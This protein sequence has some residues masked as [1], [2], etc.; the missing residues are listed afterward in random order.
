VDEPMTATAVRPSADDNYGQSDDNVALVEH[1]HK[2]VRRTKAYDPKYRDRSQKG[3][4]YY[5]DKQWEEKDKRIVKG[6]DQEAIVNNLVKPNIRLMIGLMLAQPFDWQAKPVGKNDDDLAEAVTAGLKYLANVNRVADLL[7]WVYWWGLTYGVSWTRIGPYVRW[8]DARREVCQLR[9]IDPREVGI[10]PDSREPDASDMRFLRWSRK[11]DVADAKRKWPKLGDET[12]GDSAEEN[13]TGALVEIN[14]APIDM[15]PPPSM[16][17]D[18]AEWNKYDDEDVDADAKKVTVHEVWEIKH[19]KVWLADV[20][21][22]APVEFDPAKDHDVLL[23]ARRYWQDTLPKVWM[24]VVCGPLLLESKRSIHKH[25]RIPFVPYFYERDDFGCPVSAVESIKDMQREE[26]YRRA[27]M[28]YELG[29][30]PIIVDPEVATNMGMSVKQLERHAAKRSPIWLARPDQVTYPA[31]GNMASQ[32]FDLMQHSEVAIQKAMGSNDHIMG[33][34]GPAESGKS[35]E[36]SV[37]QGATIQRA[38]VASLH[39]YH[40]S[41]GEMLCSDMCQFHD[42][43]WV[44]RV[45]DEGGRD[46]SFTLNGTGVDP[47]TGMPVKVNDINQFQYD[48]EL[49]TVPYS[50]THRQR[51]AERMVALYTAEEDPTVRAA[52]RRIAIT[53]DDLPGK[54]GILDLLDKAEQ[55][56]ANAKPEARKSFVEQIRIDGSQITPWELGQLLEAEGIKPDPSRQPGQPTPAAVEAQAGAMGGAPVEAGPPPLDPAAALKAQVDLAKHGATL[57]HQA[58]QADHDRTHQVGMALMAAQHAREQGAQQHGNA[59][60]QAE[61]AADLAPPP[62]SGGGSA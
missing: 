12:P 35:K 41:T 1:C 4:D 51:A 6:R 46:K 61:Q 15:T 3:V 30:Q 18:F 20:G 44:V 11:V 24:H 54:R 25:D 58:E 34:D 23:K 29:N 16:W 38:A 47:Q 21:A 17:D 55:A 50:P 42:D 8:D 53:L 56:K 60:E 48:I 39:L 10:D 7:R 37:Q 13:E 27:K 28:L 36:I 52:L 62:P 22:G 5:F 2:L 45:T 14:T 59:L 57:G 43:E 49:E 19:T 26:N 40:K 32:Q 9:V 31:T 33:Y